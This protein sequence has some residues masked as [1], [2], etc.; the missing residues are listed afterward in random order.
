MHLRL[1]GE[2]RATRQRKTMSGMGRF[3]RSISEL[4]RPYLRKE[5]HK[6]TLL[7]LAKIETLF[8]A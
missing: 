7:N 5:Q 1:K 2:K 4:V 6:V 3:L 8:F